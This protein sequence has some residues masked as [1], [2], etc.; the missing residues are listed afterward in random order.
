MVT[1]SSSPQLQRF[2]AELPKGMMLSRSKN[3][4]KTY[5]NYFFRWEE[6]TKPLQDVIAMP[7]NDQHIALYLISL[8]QE[9]KSSH[10]IQSTLYAIKWQHDVC[11]LV[12]PTGTF[13]KNMLECAK[14][15]ATPKRQRRGPLTPLHLKLIYNLINRVCF[16]HSLNADLVLPRFAHALIS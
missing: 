10:V 14:G 9:G 11:G 15:I 5:K 8:L 3:T 13:C 2:Q 6:W 16:N 12:D 4:T 7:A 1:E